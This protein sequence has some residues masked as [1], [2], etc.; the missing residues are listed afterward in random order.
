M[1]TIKDVAKKAGV[2]PTTVSRVLNNRGYLS[3]ETKQKVM[4]AMEEL[5]Y[6]PHAIARS[7]FSRKS[8]IIGL[9][10]PD[11]RH[12]FFA[13]WTSFIEYYAH[14]NSYKV[15]VCSSNH[16]PVREKEFVDLL[17]SN[18]LDA[19]IMGSHTLDVHEFAR[20]DYPIITFDRV[21][22]GL[23]YVCSDNAQGGI[24]AAE[25][26]LNHGCKKVAH[27]CGN[28]GLNLLSNDRSETFLHT[29][30]EHGVDPIV[31]QTRTNVFEY[32]H[33]E[34]MIDPLLRDQP[35]LDGIFAT[36]DLLAAY[37]IRACSEMN[38]HIPDDLKLI[39]Y[40][41]V[42]LSALLVPQLTTIHQPISE[43]AE[44]AVHLAIHYNS[45]NELQ[46]ANVFP[47]SLIRR[48]TC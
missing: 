13:E 16:D 33:Y 23:P 6:K 8:G 47:V 37:V 21:I 27:I 41:D 22:E 28:L 19:L 30:C 14:L 1:P 12:P 42:S 31:L 3:E 5:N 46:Q 7:L 34:E 20:L 38:I 39:G 32:N 35:D 36:S 25:S 18:Q 26:L 11:L 24:L 45:D 15:M 9:I 17:K 43:M 4:R 44:M 10:L 48:A 40:D 29:M 2:T